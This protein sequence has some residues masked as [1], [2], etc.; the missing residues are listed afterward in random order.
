MEKWMGIPDVCP[1][2]PYD[3]GENSGTR[4]RSKPDDKVSDQI[5]WFFDVV[6]GFKFI[7]FHQQVI[8]KL[9]YVYEIFSAGVR[10]KNILRAQF[11]NL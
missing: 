8:H 9:R 10:D 2:K 11:H 7:A 5:A 6:E 3:P 1:G 4:M